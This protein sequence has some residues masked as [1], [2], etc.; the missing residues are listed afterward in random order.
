MTTEE[1]HRVFVE[2][3]NG[4]GAHGSFLRAFAEAFLRADS[5]NAQVLKGAAETL[6]EKY[7]LSNYAHSP[8]DA[9]GV[10]P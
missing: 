2:V 10:Q 5:S 8:R 1:L 3:A 6:V 9:Q 4:R 7:N